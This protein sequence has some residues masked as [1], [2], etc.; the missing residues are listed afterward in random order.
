MFRIARVRIRWINPAQHDSKVVLDPQTAQPV[1]QTPRIQPGIL[2]PL[3]WRVRVRWVGFGSTESTF[4]P[5]QPIAQTVQQVS[6]FPPGRVLGTFDLPKMR[7]RLSW[8]GF[9]AGN[10]AAVWALAVMAIGLIAFAVIRLAPANPAAQTLDAETIQRLDLLTDE[11][12]VGDEVIRMSYSPLDIGRAPDI[13]DKNIDTLIRGREANP[14][15]LDLEFAEPQAIHGLI[16]DFGGMDFDLRVLVY[17]TEEG[18]PIL[19]EGEYRNQPPEPHVE[20]N[21]VNGPALVA[22]ISIEIEQFNP[23]SEPHIHVREILFKR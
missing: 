10:R 23:P 22:R 16:M 15:V 11:I 13:F 17:G 2:N 7:I 3:N 6:A 18:D 19:Y 9:D 20:L 4:P 21:F 1:H 14:F 8:L 5:K 12:P